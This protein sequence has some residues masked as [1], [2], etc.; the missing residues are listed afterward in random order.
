M[1]L[2]SDSVELIRTNAIRLANSIRTK[3][4]LV[5]LATASSF[6]Q[7]FSAIETIL[8]N[9]EMYFDDNLLIQ[10]DVQTWQ[11]FKAILLVYT[12]NVVNR[13]INLA[14]EAGFASHANRDFGASTTNL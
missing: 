14:R 13:Q 7:V 11:S 1:I 5:D 2:N 10:L 9:T 3:D 4:D 6:E 8:T 12:L